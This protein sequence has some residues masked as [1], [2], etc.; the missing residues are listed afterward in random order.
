M[1]LNLETI[2]NVVLLALTLEEIATII[3]SAFNRS[4]ANI[5]LQI[6]PTLILIGN[7][8]VIIKSLHLNITFF[9]RNLFNNKGDILIQIIYL[10]L[11]LVF[12]LFILIFYINEKTF[13][14]KI[15]I[16]FMKEKNKL[17]YING[18]GGALV[19]LFEIIYL[20]HLYIKEKQTF[21]VKKIESS[22]LLEVGGLNGAQTSINI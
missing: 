22:L 7:I 21:V 19:N 8:G 4:F 10:S 1:R 12:I 9:E 18:I 5:S 20:C 15:I 16:L 11:L 14:E 6:Y 17:I 3:Y 13:D 2:S